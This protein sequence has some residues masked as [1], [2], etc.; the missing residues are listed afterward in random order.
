MRPTAGQARVH[1]FD[2]VRD[3]LKVRQRIAV[4]IQ[5][6]AAELFLTVRDNLTTYARF[7]GLL[8]RRDSAPGRD[9]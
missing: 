6:S 4:V 9:G 8:R 1:G 2:V 7:H 5:E 3:G